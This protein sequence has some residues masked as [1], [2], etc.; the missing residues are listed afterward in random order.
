M[1]TLTL[2]FK[3]MTHLFYP[4]AKSLKS[5]TINGVLDYD[6]ILIT[7][8]KDSTSY[9]ID[10]LDADI[11]NS[12]LITVDEAGIPSVADTYSDCCAV[13]TCDK[14]LHLDLGEI[15]QYL[16]SIDKPVYPLDIPP[17]ETCT[18]KF[19][20]YSVQHGSNYYYEIRISQKGIEREIYSK[21]ATDYV[22]YDISRKSLPKHIDFF[23]DIRYISI[24]DIDVD[25]FLNKYRTLL[26][27][28]EFINRINTILVEQ[29]G[30]FTHKL[31]LSGDCRDL[32]VCENH[33]DYYVSLF[34]C[35]V[36]T[37]STIYAVVQILDACI[38]EGTLLIIDDFDNVPQGTK[39]VCLS[40]FKL[41]SEQTGSKLILIDNDEFAGYLK[42]KPIK[43]A[44]HLAYRGENSYKYIQPYDVNVDLTTHADYKNS[45]AK[46]HVH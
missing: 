34:D 38:D 44:V 45:L 18:I 21:V 46:K 13:V 14:D 39:S 3:D 35:N 16:S 31:S 32:L 11:H 7:F 1:L 6:E 36:T 10:K 17:D 24:R 20:Y 5:I 43:N 33:T 42:H 15:F 22:T 29:M 40:I 28:T 37:K 30:L 4:G 12:D 2:L 23:K 19:E 26:L 27:D 25:E 9:P 8:A 41:Y